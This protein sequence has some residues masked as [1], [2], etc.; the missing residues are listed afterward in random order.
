MLQMVIYFFATQEPG[1]I[2]CVKEI[3]I[4]EIKASIKIVLWHSTGKICSRG[5]CAI[6]CEKIFRSTSR[7]G[8]PC[9]CTAIHL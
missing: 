8:S 6:F 4:A 9:P 2:F 3:D 7:S 1:E 5:Q